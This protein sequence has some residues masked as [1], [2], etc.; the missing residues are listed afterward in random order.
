[1]QQ[2]ILVTGATAGFGREIARQLVAGGHRVVATGRR[3]ERLQALADELGPALLPFVL[4][5]TDMAALRDLPRSLPEGWREIDVLVNNAGLALGVERAQDSDIANWEQMIATNVSGLAAITHALLPGMIARDRGYVIAIGSVAGI[6]P[7][8]GG[9]VY[10]ATKAFVDQ[11]MRNLRTDVLGR[12]VRVTNIAP[13]L[14]SGTEFSNVRLKDD[15]RAAKVYEN[16][17]ALTA[18]D[19]ARTVSWLIALPGHVNINQIEMMPTC[20]APAGLAIE[21]GMG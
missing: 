19:I 2:T 12:H 6:Y 11:F 3:R 9:N 4:D 14:C 20:Q 5:M 18:D 17:E 8:Q 13:G 21:R 7:Y 16:T 10:G 1:M 15:D